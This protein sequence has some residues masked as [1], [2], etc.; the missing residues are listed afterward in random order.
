MKRNGKYA[1]QRNFWKCKE[2]KGKGNGRKKDKDK[3]EQSKKLTENYQNG[4]ENLYSA[5]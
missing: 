4:V 3:T 1:K 5:I 2:R